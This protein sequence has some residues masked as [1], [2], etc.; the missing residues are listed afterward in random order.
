MNLYERDYNQI[1]KD[2]IIEIDRVM[3]KYTK[4]LGNIKIYNSSYFREQPKAGRHYASLFPNNYLDIEDLQNKKELERK[5]K[6]FLNLLENNGAKEQEILNFIKNEKAYHVIGSIMKEYRFG[7]HDAYLFP[8]F[9]LGNSYK[10]D[11]LLVGKSSGGYE[12]ILVELEAPYGR[13][14]IKSGDFGETI[15]KGIN[16]IEDW[17]IWL[18]SN[19][20]AFNE[21]L[22]KSC[23]GELSHEFYKYEPNRF[24]YAIVV[25]RRENFNEKTYILKRSLRNQQNIN[26]L[27]YDNLI[28][29][30]SRLIEEPSY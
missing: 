12:F 6:Q 7:H 22:L 26:L 11:Y 1:S 15:R 3:E 13:I 17:K 18:N 23:K 9:Q 2:E 21:P 19:Y 20:S 25:G 14:T 8:E 4:K 5:N 24:H 29:K 28:D 10:V 16:Q 30:A 27:H